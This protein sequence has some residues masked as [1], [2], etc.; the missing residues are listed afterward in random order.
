MKTTKILLRLI[1]FLFCVLTLTATYLIATYLP[2][3]P[4]GTE[5]LTIPSL[6][7]TTLSENDER[8]PPDRYTLIFD[9]RTDAATAPG[10]V[11][12]QEPSGG[13]SRRVIPTHSPCT[14]R[15]TLSTG[16]ATLSVPPLIGRSAKEAAV[17]LRAAGL[18]VRTQSTLRNDLSPGQI[19]SVDPPEGTVMQEGQVITL[20]VSEVSTRRVVRVP[21][22][23][24]LERTLANSTLILR[25]LVPNDPTFAYSDT[26][27]NGAVISQY[28]LPGTLVPSGTQATLTL[29]RGND[30]TPLA[31]E[32]E[33]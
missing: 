9:Y 24:G 19:L 13:A 14:L 1:Y 11:L 10:T 21:D 26:V 30:T 23:R 22:V 3:R 28:P 32:F 5:T 17:T 15:L 2:A 8:L 7:G 33:E 16:P 31:E 6:I 29:S 20:T 25:G 4:E 18:I 12:L 27:P